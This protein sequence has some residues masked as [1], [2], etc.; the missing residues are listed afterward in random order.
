L[1]R[2]WYRLG[3]RTSP[4]YVETFVDGTP[5]LSVR[6]DSF[7]QGEVALFARG[8]EADF[9]DARVTSYAAYRQQLV[10]GPSPLGSAWQTL[11]GNWSGENRVL[12]SAPQTG[13]KGASRLALAGRNDWDGYVL[14]VGVKSGEA[15]AGG[16]VAGYRDAG[17]YVVFR[18]AGAKSILPFRGRQQFLRYRNGKATVVRDE[19]ATKLLEYSKNDYANLTIR[20]SGG[21]L[22]VFSGQRMVAQMADVSLT[23]GRVG[24]WAQGSAPV[25]FRDIE[26]SFPPAPQAPKVAPRFATDALMVGWASAAGEWSVRN[27]NG[28]SA[29]WNTGDFYGDLNIDYDWKRSP[30]RK[31]EMALRARRGEWKSGYV[32]RFESDAAKDALQISLLRGDKVLKQASYSW[33]S[34]KGDAAKPVPLRVRLEGDGI[35]FSGRGQAALLVAG[36]RRYEY[37]QP[38]R[39]GRYQCW[40]AQH[41]NGGR[42]LYGGC[43]RRAPVGRSTRRLH[44]HRSADRLVC[45]AGRMDR[46]FA[47]AVLL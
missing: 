10:A 21:A 7:G 37:S 39:G 32:A 42:H 44:L 38:A 29:Q 35:L 24:L 4:G 25:S 15:G 28:T 36:Q 1:P 8:L 20:L 45:A 41:G 30:N 23:S 34:Y 14:N 31:M 2:Q 22:A 3:V 18:W 13:D 27:E 11:G 12:T 46:L 9:D 5:L 33:K 26:L 43:Q 17:N 47:L 40:D 6:D 19:A 16:L